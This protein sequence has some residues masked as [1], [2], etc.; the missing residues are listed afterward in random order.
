MGVVE[1]VV[2]EVV[3][4]E[5]LDVMETGTDGAELAAVVFA[6]LAG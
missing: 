4:L 3:E 5:V 1:A 2:L 6:G